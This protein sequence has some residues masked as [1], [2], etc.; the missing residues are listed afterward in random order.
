VRER[1]TDPYAEKIVECIDRS[2]GRIRA[3]RVHEELVAM[4]YQGSE[5]TTR[6]VSPR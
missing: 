1:A 2:H 3:D 6:R 4:G 5:R